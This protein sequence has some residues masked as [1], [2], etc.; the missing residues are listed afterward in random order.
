MN[1]YNLAQL[2]WTQSLTHK[3]LKFSLHKN[4]QTIP[5]EPPLTSQLKSQNINKETTTRMSV[6]KRFILA[7]VAATTQAKTSEPP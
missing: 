3:T 1:S 6:R 5:D 4:L 2:Q 7:K